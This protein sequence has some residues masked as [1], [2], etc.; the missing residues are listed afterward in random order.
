MISYQVQRNSRSRNLRLRITTKAEVIV[1]APPRVPDHLISRFVQEH[2]DWIT[3]HLSKMKEKQELVDDDQ[4]M[5]FG[6]V[7]QKVIHDDNSGDVPV[8]INNQKLHIHPVTNTKPSI[9]RTLTTFLKTTAQKYIVPR[10]KKLAEVMGMTYTSL[11]LRDQKTRWG[12]CS[13]TGALNFNWRLVQYPVPVIDYVIVHEL[14]H[15]R[16]MNHSARFWALVAKYDP[17][18]QAHRRWLKK[19]GSTVE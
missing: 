11:T 12:S 16:E 18:Y 4:L 1:S 3:K 5:I 19:Y 8:Y 7:Y 6:K 17:E 9:D 13:S 15:R 14:A 10:T 2:S